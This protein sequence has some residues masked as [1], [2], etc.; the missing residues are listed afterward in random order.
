M[1]K[2][3]LMGA[4]SLTLAGV[5]SA[6]AQQCTGNTKTGCAN[7]GAICS[8]VFSGVGPTGKC[9][10][11]AGL[12]KGEKECDCIGAPPIVLDGTWQADDGGLYYLRQIGNELWWAGLSNDTLECATNLHRGIAFTNV[13]HGTISGATATGIWADVPRGQSLQSG[14][15]TLNVANDVIQRQAVTGGF[16]ATHWVRTGP[17]AAPDEIFSLFD[18]V[19]KNQNA[20]KDHSLLDNL[21]PAKALP[22]AIFGTLI[23][24]GRDP[25]PMHVNYYSSV[26]R[27]YNDFICLNGNDSPP[28]GDI[29]FDI[30]VDRQELNVQ[31]GFWTN[32]WETS[33]GITPNNFAAKLNQQNFQHIESVMYGGTTECGDSGPTSF[34]LPGWQQPGGGSLIFNGVPVEGHMDVSGGYSPLYISAILG[35]P[36]AFGARVRITGNLALDCGHGTFHDC[37]EDKP[38]NQNQEIHPT[39]AIDLVQDF[40]QPRQNALLTGPWSN[41]DAG[42]YYLRQIGNTVW[43]LGMS[44][45]EGRSF[46]NVFLGTLQNGQLS[47]NWVDVPL[48][49]S[50]NAGTLSMI[51]T[52]GVLSTTLV[53]TAVTGGFGGGIWQKL[54]DVGNRT[55]TVVIDNATTSAAS[56]PSLPVAVPFEITVGHQRVQ[57][58][59]T[60]A[61]I[62]KLSTGQQVTQVDLN[63]RITI[64]PARL[65][66]LPVSVNY[67]GYRANWTIAPSDQ[68]A[69]AR[70]QAM[71]VPRV[72][73]LANFAVNKTTVTD[74]D[75][76][77][78][79]LAAQQTTV[80]IVPDM[81][82]HYHIEEANER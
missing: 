55:I 77:A 57:A 64:D 8:P 82:V 74:R 58:Q 33:H 62:V 11:P 27:G 2:L 63:A 29:D 37:D 76:E 49:S 30:A 52:Q 24:T 12:P 80:K 42:T 48:G 54:Y 22:V 41:N 15:L 35:T 50:Q 26:G 18:K 13:F 59:P 25:V 32:G 16:G 53:R 78:A 81:T 61:R 6:H 51:A 4:I 69:G 67:L 65:G 73:P 38:S 47:G 45:D 70:N 56:W 19:K 1:R 43:W 71:K 23:Q 5:P 79:T 31:N 72:L 10:T 46:A 3:I 20:I 66:G 68:Q 7:E 21:K 60:N 40:S 28:D 34:L 14:T 36:I 9:T 75:V 17:P 39:Y 44:V